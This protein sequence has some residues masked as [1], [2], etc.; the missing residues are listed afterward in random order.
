MVRLLFRLLA[1]ISLAVAV[2]LSVLDATRSVAASQLVLT[3][4]GDSL[5]AAAPDALEN[6][7][8]AVEGSWPFLWDTIA[9][10]LLA[11]PGPLVFAFLALILYA[12]GRRPA[13]HED[14]AAG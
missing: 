5:K 12:V 11:A 10:W 7:R 6:A 8:A 1:T 3:P 4:L 9:V 14:F 2:I 13:R